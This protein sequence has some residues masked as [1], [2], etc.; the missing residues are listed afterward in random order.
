MAII[1]GF[2]SRTRERVLLEHDTEGTN[3]EFWKEFSDTPAWQRFAEIYCRTKANFD[4][5]DAAIH[6]MYPD[7][8]FFTSDE[9]TDVVV[10]M[11]ESGGD[12]KDLLDRIPVQ[13]DES[14]QEAHD[15]PRDKNGKALT[16]AQIKWSEMTRF[17]EEHSMRE[18]NER[19][20]V[21]PAFADFIRTNLRRDMTQVIDGD[22]RVTNPHL[23]QIKAP[24]QAALADRRLV[25]FANAYRVMPAEAVR[26]AKRFDF[27]PLTAQTFIDDEAQAIKLGLL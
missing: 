14:A 21:D 1:N 23:D 24:T 9:V 18:I 27:N 26:K 6:K 4:R 2:D 20:R 8:K 17:A 19:K 25:D 12:E 7:Q 10:T 22:A 3:S 5:I 11:T 15:V 16:Q 13:I